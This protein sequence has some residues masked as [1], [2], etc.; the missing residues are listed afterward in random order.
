MNGSSLPCTRSRHRGKD[1]G[2]QRAVWT[3]SEAVLS[4]PRYLGPLTTSAPLNAHLTI[5]TFGEHSTSDGLRM[6]INEVWSKTAIKMDAD[7]VGGQVSLRN[8][9]T[10]TVC[11][12]LR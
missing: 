6:L 11:F 9:A 5:E 7:T 2:S 8:V 10:E 3:R 12:P 4:V 1:S